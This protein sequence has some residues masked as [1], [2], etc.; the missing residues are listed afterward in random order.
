[1][2]TTKARIMTF[3]SRFLEKVLSYNVKVNDAQ[4]PTIQTTITVFLPKLKLRHKTPCIFFHIKN[5]NGSTLCRC[6]SPILLAEKLE[7]L[8]AD[9]RG[10]RMLDEWQQINDI[11]DRLSCNEDIILDEKYIDRTDFMSVV[12]T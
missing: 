11:A 5:G 4:V 6:S 1:M 2:G 10:D 9:L 3:Q 7:E 12:I 8:A